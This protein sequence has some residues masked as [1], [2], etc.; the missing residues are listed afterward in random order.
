MKQSIQ[1]YNIF[2]NAKFCKKW[3]LVL[4]SKIFITNNYV[5]QNDLPNN[6]NLSHLSKSG[7]GYDLLKTVLIPKQGV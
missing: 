1:G 3:Y 4:E 2:I 5:V 7:P 6:M